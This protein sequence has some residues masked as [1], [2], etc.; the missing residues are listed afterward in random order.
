MKYRKCQGISIDSLDN[1]PIFEF[2]TINATA[3]AQVKVAIGEADAKVLVVVGE[4]EGRKITAVGTAEAEVIQL[5]TN[6][7]GQENYRTIEVARALA[8]A[9]VPLVPQIVAGG[10]N[11]DSSSFVDVLLANLV[12]K[13]L[14]SKSTPT[15][16]V[17]A[18]VPVPT[19][20]PAPTPPAAT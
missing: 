18:P 7:V 12:Q 17:P 16:P 20:T 4:A 2:K 8:G 6:A 13:D 1:I 5:K 11:G 14:A 15:L 19:P 10:G 9:H 3:D